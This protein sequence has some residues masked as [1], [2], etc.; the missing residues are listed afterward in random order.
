MGAQPPAPCWRY[1]LNH[2]ASLRRRPAAVIG[3][4]ENTADLENQK[5]N[6]LK[7]RNKPKMPG[8]VMPSES[9][10]MRNYRRFGARRHQYGRKTLCFF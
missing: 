5:E 1:S 4:R 10:T 9:T 7:T 6:V 3:S 2:A 8:W